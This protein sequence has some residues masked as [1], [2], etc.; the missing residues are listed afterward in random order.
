MEI[1]PGVFLSA[2]SAA[3]WEPDPDVGGEMHVLCEGVGQQAGLSRFAGE[4]DHP[5]IRWTLPGRETVL[6]LEGTARIQ[7]DDG[8]ILSVAPGD[9]FSIPAGADTVWHLT[10]PFKEFW[11]IEE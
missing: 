3:D 2:L 10:L 6:V 11:V 1:A 5:P 7:I 8:P 9:L 4:G